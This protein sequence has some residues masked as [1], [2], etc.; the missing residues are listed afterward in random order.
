MVTSS[1]I[2]GLKAMFAAQSISLLSKGLLIILLTRYFLTAEEYGLLFFAISI[3]SVALL[4]ANL[5]LAKS[6]ARYLAE[7]RRT[8]P[9]QVPHIL[10][11]TLKYNLVMILVVSA[12]VVSFSEPVSQLLDEPRVAPLLVGGV[13]YI[14][15]S[16]LKTFVSLSFQGLNSVD[17]SAKTD[18][19]ANVSL[20]VFI[21]G[22]LLLGLGPLG[23]ILGYTVGF[24]L[25]VA[26]GFVILYVKFY[27]PL[28]EGVPQES[29]LSKRILRYS[30]P[31][32]VTRGAVMLDSRVDAILVGYFLNPLAV[33]YYMLGKQITD[34]VIAPA[35]T[36]GF[37][38]SPTY[39]EQKVTNKLER[40]ANL[41]E[42]TFE[43]VVTLYVPAAVGMAILAEP[44]VRLI[45]GAEYLGAVPVVQVFSLYVLLRAIDKITNDSLD[46]I[47]RA[48]ARAYAKS[49]TAVA[50]FALNIAL[51]PTLGVVGAALA[52]VI[53]YVFLV[54]FEVYL[55]Y[56][57]F[58]LSLTRLA[59]TTAIVCLVTLGV[60]LPVLA[61]EPFISGLVTLGAAIV[62]GIVMWS[63]LVS[64]S[65]LLSFRRVVGMLR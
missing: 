14:A 50:N 39:G 4:F 25:A 44:T 13:G 19:V 48:G 5:G 53:T 15:F 16:S 28:D 42:T 29:G 18:I 35:T 38:I 12:A 59:R 10:W 2:R 26:V 22:F 61:F 17:W 63:V 24:A 7:Y 54:G 58:S 40:A 60:A 9:A 47:G 27:R 57:E 52:T 56:T 3:L 36:I 1:I 30:I 20:I 43:Y 11:S 65:G 33:G 32:A 62:L 31:L 8:E 64:V 41:Y 23:A 55:I 51:I 49:A 46:F 37:S 34:F 6:A 21:V 45:F